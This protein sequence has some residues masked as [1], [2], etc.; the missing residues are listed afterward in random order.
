LNYG[1]WNSGVLAHANGLD[2]QHIATVNNISF[3]NCSA[4]RMGGNAFWIGHLYGFNTSF[5][6]ISF[7]NIS[8]TDCARDLIQLGATVGTKISNVYGRRIGYVALNGISPGVPKY[9]AGQY[10]VAL[11]CGPCFGTTVVGLNLTSVSGGCVDL[12][13]MMYTS[14][15]GFTL[16]TP[17]PGDPEYIEDSIGLVG[18]AGASVAGGPNFSYGIQAAPAGYGPYFEGTHSISGGSIINMSDGAIRAY[19][20]HNSMFSDLNIVSPS[21]PTGVPIQVGNIGTADINRSYGNVFSNLRMQ[22]SPPTPQPCIAELPG[23]SPFL[24]TDVNQVLGIEL[25]DPAGNAFV[26]LKDPNSG[27]IAS[28][29][30]TID[31]STF[32]GKL[33]FYNGFLVENTA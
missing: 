18:F 22:Y 7:N 11:D 6:G 23:S 20:S 10:A 15:S 5:S 32:S 19:G 12:D 24:A 21:Q 30:S 27:S 8:G 16:R 14:M 28:I 13:G 17:L 1:G 33:I 2:A 29:S 25:V 31:S 4:T 26:F 9:E 3:S